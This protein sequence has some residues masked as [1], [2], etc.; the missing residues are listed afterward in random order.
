VQLLVVHD[1]GHSWPGSTVPPPE[2]F[3]PVGKAPNA[4]DTILDFFADPGPDSDADPDP[5]PGR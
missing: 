5:G 3:G 2:G 1:A 4:T